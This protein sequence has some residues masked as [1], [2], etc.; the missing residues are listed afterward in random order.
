[1][2]F[3]SWK[4]KVIQK[5][6]ISLEVGAETK[7]V[8]DVQM[9]IFAHCAIFQSWKFVTL[10]RTYNQRKPSLRAF[11]ILYATTF[12]VNW[13]TMIK[14]S[15]KSEIQISQFAQWA[16]TCSAIQIWT[17]NFQVPKIRR[18]NIITWNKKWSKSQKSSRI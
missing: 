3:W 6:T 7:Y 9:K 10:R 4:S 15:K 16:I 11:A 12:C 8:A 17:R 2:V 5:L 18:L 13:N 14:K 1:M